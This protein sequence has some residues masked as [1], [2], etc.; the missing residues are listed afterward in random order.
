M[1]YSKTIEF[2]EAVWFGNNADLHIEEMCSVS[3]KLLSKVT[4]RFC[5]DA[6]GEIT[7]PQK[8]IDEDWIL[9]RCLGLPPIMRNSVF[10]GLTERRFEVSQA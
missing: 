3:D 7:L 5:A 10:D 6:E 4:P 2:D 9:F 8:T 1:R